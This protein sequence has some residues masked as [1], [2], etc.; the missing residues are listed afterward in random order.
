MSKILIIED[1]KNLRLLYQQD[2]ERDGFEVVTAGT[3][4]DGIA[5]VEADMPDLV[6][7][8]KDPL[9]DIRNTESISRVMQNGRLYDAAT[10]NEVAPRVKKRAPFWWEKQQR[11]EK[12][13]VNY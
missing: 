3:A 9:A 5:L 11:E 2:F 10:L 7:M 13:V 8:D 4:A 6:V 12:A 1:E